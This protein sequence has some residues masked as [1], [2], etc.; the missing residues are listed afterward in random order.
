MNQYDL[1]ENQED[2][3]IDRDKLITA[4]LKTFEII[5]QHQ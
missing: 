5:N 1:V 3:L 2:S 4:V